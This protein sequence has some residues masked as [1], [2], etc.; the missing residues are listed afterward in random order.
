MY[1]SATG[2]TP[3][4]SLSGNHLGEGPFVVTSVDPDAPTPQDPFLASVRHFLGGNF[5]P[6]EKDCDD[7]RLVNSTSAVSE[8]LQPA[9]PAGSDPH[10]CV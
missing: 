5:T 2:T 9:P 3:T 6:E 10:R 1:S 7:V 8:W 4:F